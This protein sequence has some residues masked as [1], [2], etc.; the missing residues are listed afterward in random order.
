MG[1]AM[2]HIL[3]ESYSNSE[4]NFRL[5]SLIFIISIGVFIGMERLFV[6]CGIAHQHGG[7]EDHDHS[8]A[9]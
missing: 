1:D 8:H 4:V 3:P 2:I 5:V 6:I 7:D 9:D